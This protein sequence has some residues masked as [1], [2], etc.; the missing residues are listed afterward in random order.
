MRSVLVGVCWAIFVV[1]ISLLILALTPVR[2]FFEGVPKLFGG[3]LLILLGIS[4]AVLTARVITNSVLKG[5]MIAT[6]V[7]VIGWPTS[8]FLHGFLYLYY[9]TE[10]V[11]YVLFFFVFPLIF[12]IGAIGVIS[13]VYLPPFIRS[14]FRLFS[15][16]NFPPQ[17]AL[18]A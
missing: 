16:V 3:I 10:P 17:G 14:I 2:Q 5:F 15:Q 12:A 8:L 13:Q 18:T 1:F 4:L 9:P 7:A 6:G 11:T